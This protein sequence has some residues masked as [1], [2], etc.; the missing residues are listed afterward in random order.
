M[1]RRRVKERDDVAVWKRE[2][3]R[4]E[5]R[6]ANYKED[7]PTR[8]TEERNTE[9]RRRLEER[10]TTKAGGEGDIQGEDEQRSL[11]KGAGQSHEVGLSRTQENGS[12][13]GLF[14]S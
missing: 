3:R 11:K 7:D 12:S 4:G 13:D 8:R 1:H 10:D 5:E 9:R 14:L 2:E 6:K